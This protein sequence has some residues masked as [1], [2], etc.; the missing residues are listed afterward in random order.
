LGVGGTAAGG[1]RCT[2]NRSVAADYRLTTNNRRKRPK[3]R[4]QDWAWG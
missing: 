3:V 2:W 1:N 4:L